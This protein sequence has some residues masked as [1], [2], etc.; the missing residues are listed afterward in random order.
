MPLSKIAAMTRSV[1]ASVPAP[2]SRPAP[3]EAVRPDPEAWSLALGIAGGDSR[4]LAVSNG[5]RVVTVLNRPR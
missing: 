1:R 3:V 5:G 4:R 2:A